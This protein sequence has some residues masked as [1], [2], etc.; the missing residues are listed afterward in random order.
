MA[1]SRKKVVQ[2]SR[3]LSLFERGAWIWNLKN[4]MKDVKMEQLYNAESHGEFTVVQ[5]TE[6]DNDQ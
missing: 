4:Q 3:E 2:D 6:I 5:L 1:W